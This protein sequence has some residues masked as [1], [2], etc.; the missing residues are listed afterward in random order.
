MA[1]IDRENDNAFKPRTL[2][3]ARAL[4]TKQEADTL[5]I[6]LQMINKSDDEPS[7]LCYT[8]NLDE[9]THKFG[10]NYDRNAYRKIRKNLEG[11]GFKHI[12]LLQDNGRFL[13]FILFQSLDW[14]ADGSSVTVKLGEDFKAKLVELKNSK[15][16][17]IT[18]Y[19]ISYTLPM[20]SQYSKRLYPM[21]LEF[22]KTGWRVDTIDDLREKL[23]IPVS[24]KYNDIKRF[25][26]D[27]A[28]EDINE[29]TDLTIS[30]VENRNTGRGGKR[31]ESVKWII[32]KKKT[33]ILDV[34][35]DGKI[36]ESVEEELD[37]LTATY[38]FIISETISG[39]IELS[40]RDIIAI[41]KDA[42]KYSVEPAEIK[43]RLNI[44]LEKRGIENFVGYARSLMKHYAENKENKGNNN[45]FDNFNSREYDWDEILKEIEF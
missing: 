39:K 30:Y 6:V 36:E 11:T 26:L 2:N 5:D 32:Q 42:V 33:D 13:E 21:L 45:S 25:V 15:A 20:K 8:I 12:G 16:G 28:V 9:Y 10:L 18:Y 38:K 37:P 29:M 1:Q 31:I 35:A 17:G 27:R 3:E 19:S 34:N 44:I 41:A 4:F 14:A 22:L 7:N 23:Q 24:Y 40:E 43:N